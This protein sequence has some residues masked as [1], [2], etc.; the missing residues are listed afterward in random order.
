MKL[1]HRFHPLA[2]ILATG[3]TAA[4]AASACA[5]DF[6]IAPSSF[7][8]IAGE[9]IEV[10]L[11]IGDDFPG[12]AYGRNPRHLRAFVAV[13]PGSSGQARPIPGNTG[14]DP[15]GLL[16]LDKPGLYVIGYRSHRSEA[17]LE[18]EKFED[19]LVEEGLESISKIRSERGQSDQP[20]REAYSRC[21]KTLLRV[22][23][24]EAEE[25]ATPAEA[26]EGFD[27]PLGLTLELIPETDPYQ[28]RPDQP[29][30]VRLLYQG[31]P[32]AGVLIEA[33]HASGQIEHLSGRTDKEG[34][35]A[36]TL[37]AAGVWRLAGVYMSEAN[38]IPGIDWESLWASLT[39]ELPEADAAG[40]AQT[41]PTTRPRNVPAE[42][43]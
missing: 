29:L 9:G 42:R 33:A 6:W 1:P 27:R 13:G 34:R 22:T 2:C 7:R 11:R 25:N 40:E 23:P 32:A 16:Q 43:E 36:F 14:E 21:A 4:I 8:P 31:E 20:G 18:A 5:H 41:R 17:T 10:A 37:P 39:F 15:A 24:G 3:L 35:V 28:A 19:Y 30:T 12:E 38:D 26:F